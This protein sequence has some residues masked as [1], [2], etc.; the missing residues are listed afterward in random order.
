[1]PGQPQLIAEPDR[2]M[3]VV[4]TWPDRSL[5]WEAASWLYNLLPPQNIYSFCGK[6]H[7]T[8]RNQAVRDI[9]LKAPPEIEHVVLMD[10]DMRPG[11]ASLPVLQ[12]EGDV[13]GSLY[14]IPNMGGWADPHAV[15]L[16]LVRVARKVFDVVPPPWFARVYNQEDMT[17]WAQCECHFFAQK[18]LAAG[19]S[20]TRAGWC[21]HDVG[22]DF[23]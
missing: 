8:A 6:D 3:A 17:R 20:V 5:T 2:I 4:F 22:K 7:Q 16:G 14:P 11:P 18:A 13:V 21:E 10:R 23:H 12:A 1:M 15:H 9:I 19:F